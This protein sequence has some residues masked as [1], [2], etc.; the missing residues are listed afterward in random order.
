[1]D[2]YRAGEEEKVTWWQKWREDPVRMVLLA[3][4]LAVVG[5]LGI[6]LFM[7]VFMWPSFVLPRPLAY[8]YGPYVTGG[9]FGLAIVGGWSYCLWKAVKKRRELRAA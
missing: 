8:E 9:E 2:P 3:P 6:G 1:M 7:F 4:L 5:F